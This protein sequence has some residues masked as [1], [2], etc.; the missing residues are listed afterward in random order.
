[1]PGGF[2]GVGCGQAH[3]EETAFGSGGKIGWRHARL[4][5]Q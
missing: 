2:Y 3:M 5:P 1:M 4:P